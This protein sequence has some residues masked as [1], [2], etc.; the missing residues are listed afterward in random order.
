M[1][2]IAMPDDQRLPPGS[3]RELIAAVHSLYSAAGKPSLRHISEWIRQRDDLPG[4][5]SHEGVSEALNGK[6]PRWA[7]LESLVRVLV[8]HR[9]VGGSDEHE[10]VERIHALW[11]N[12][13]SLS[14]SSTTQEMNEP[15]S[16][17][18]EQR[19]T[20]V[21]LAG[22]GDRAASSSSGQDTTAAGTLEGI[23]AEL[24]TAQRQEHEERMNVYR[25]ILTSSSPR[26][27]LIDALSQATADECISKHGV[28]V[29]VWET[30]LYY[31]FVLS[32]GRLLCVR[33][34]KA[35]GRT[36][37]DHPWEPDEDA[38][39]FYQRLV[40]AVRAAGVDPGVGLNDPIESV[41]RLSEMLVEIGQLR[42]QAV[43]GYRHI[44]WKVVQ[45][46]G[47]EDAAW[48]F[49]ET[50]LIPAW[51][52]SYEI[53]YDRLDEIDWAE[54]LRGKGWHGAEEALDLARLVQKSLI[55]ATESR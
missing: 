21:P 6:V 8:E 3:R 43:M 5:L 15:P 37:A 47:F 48:Y 40:A 19:L 13:D 39:H 24:L 12:V 33:L 34:E 20:Q 53:S 35:D 38:G 32:S 45:K 26:D 44:I 7:N 27:A 49:T 18:A 28:R 10:V 25:R 11:E 54:H 30:N 17:V 50:A 46:E 36:I 55:T 4:T 42:A 23:R 29:S 9:R 41:K 2:G 22:T 51:E 52:P 14:S 1:V 16:E 31:R